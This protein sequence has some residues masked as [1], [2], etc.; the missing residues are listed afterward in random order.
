MTDK[1]WDLDD[2]DLQ[3][4]AQSYSPALVSWMSL[5]VSELVLLLSLKVMLH[6]GNDRPQ[7]L[8]RYN[9]AVP[10]TAAAAN[11]QWRRGS[12]HSALAVQF[13]VVAEPTFTTV[14]PSPTDAAEITCKPKINHRLQVSAVANW[15]AR[16]NRAVDRAGRLKMRD[17]NYRHIKNAGVEN[18][19]L[20]LSAPK[21]QGWKMRD[22]AVM[23]SQNTCGTGS[24]AL[25]SYLLRLT[26][27][28][29]SNYL[30]DFTM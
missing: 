6:F 19:G 16:R 18:A 17:W 12:E 15:P 7:W 1:A 11:D 20:E 10:P 8:F 21:L 27:H 5:S 3:H 26:Q 9:R 23:E 30:S 2:L 24:V 25:T 4:W 13:N 28:D 22:H 14:A 29:L